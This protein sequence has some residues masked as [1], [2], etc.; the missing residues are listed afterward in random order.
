MGI[1]EEIVFSLPVLLIGAL[2][3][4][5]CC[6]FCCY[7]IRSSRRSRDLL[8]SEDVEQPSREFPRGLIKVKYKSKWL[9]KSTLKD[10]MCTICL[11]DFKSR[12]EINM[13]RCGHA[14][15]HKCIMKWLEIRETCP[16]CQHNVQTNTRSSE[17]T[18]LL[19]A[20]NVDV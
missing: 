18:P 16:I 5:L 1:P 10:D 14:Y 15:H 20:S 12:E 9:K 13:C 11:D 7:L 17:R 4:G 8:D 6:T 2:V 3:C 19:G